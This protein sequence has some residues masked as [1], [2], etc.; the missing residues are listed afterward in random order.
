[1]SKK[2]KKLPIWPVL[3]LA[4]VILSAVLLAP[5]CRYLYT[6]DFVKRGDI[7]LAQM[8]AHDFETADISSFEKPIFFI[9]AGITRTNASCLDL[10]TGAYDIFSVFAV[11]DALDLDT[12]AASQYIIDYLN[13]LGYSYTAPTEEDWNMYEEE[14][15]ALLPLWKSFPWYSSMAETEHCI[16]V[17]LSGSEGGY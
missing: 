1:M 9:G 8:L 14:L 10:S 12:V 15:S 4:S 3:V 7:Q 6:K 13:G 17:Q 5:F 11:S 16:I 2:E